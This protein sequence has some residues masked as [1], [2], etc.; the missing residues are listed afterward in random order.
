MEN[1]IIF[2]TS[3]PYNYYHPYGLPSSLDIKFLLKNTIDYNYLFVNLLISF[4]GIWLYFIHPKLFDLIKSKKKINFN[5]IDD[6]I[7][8]LNNLLG[9]LDKLTEFEIN[10]NNY[11]NKQINE[12]NKD[13]FREYKKKLS[14][15]GGGIND[16]QIT[17][18]QIH[19][20]YI[21]KTYNDMGIF[22]LLFPYKINNIN[23]PLFNKF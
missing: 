12:L 20:N 3:P 22:L 19:L 13:L 11:R 23:I 21:I 6:I 15:I 10:E 16:E 1:N 9:S 18:R 7:K 8:N 17:Y 4:E 5:E 14:T 2:Y